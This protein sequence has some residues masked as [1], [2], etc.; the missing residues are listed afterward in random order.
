MATW[1]IYSTNDGKIAV[2]TPYNA[3]VVAECKR[4]MGRWIDLTIAKRD[5]SS[6]VVK[7]WKLDAS[8]R[9]AIEALCVE[10]FPDPDALIERV[11][12]W[13][14]QDYGSLHAPTIDGYRVAWFSRDNYSIAQAKA[15]EPFEIMEVVED[16]LTSGGSR[17]NPRLYGKLTLRLRCRPQ[18]VA[19]GDGWTAEVID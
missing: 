14:A 1:K 4:R 3:Q 19:A 11:I 8:H 18:A 9:Q 10:L 6:R 13:T 5:G 15:G 16:D 12:T 7:A 17:N 2:S